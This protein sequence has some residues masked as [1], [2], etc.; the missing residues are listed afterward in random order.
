MSAFHV[1]P[2]PAVVA[3]I[4]DTCGGHAAFE[5]WGWLHPH[6]IND[7]ARKGRGG[8][9]PVRGDLHHLGAYRERLLDRGWDGA[10]PIGPAAAAALG[11]PLSHLQ[12]P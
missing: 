8:R 4:W 1:T 11:I 12:G 3:E 10:P 5:R 7:L 2:R 6:F 9:G